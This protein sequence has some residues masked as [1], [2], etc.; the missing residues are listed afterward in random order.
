MKVVIIKP[1]DEHLLAEFEEAKAAHLQAIKAVEDYRKAH[2]GEFDDTLF[3][4][5]TDAM[6]A[7]ISAIEAIRRK[8]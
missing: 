7:E 5:M 6:H 4:A 8:G 1:E 2:N 3:D